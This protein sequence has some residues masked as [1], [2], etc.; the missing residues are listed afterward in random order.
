M[1]R[2]VRTS[3]LATLLGL[4]IL[5]S[6]VPAAA[7]RPPMA[8]GV[9]MYDYKSVAVFD[10][11]VEDSN[12]SVNPKTNPGDLQYPAVWSMWS[13]WGSTTTKKFPTGPIMDKL[14]ANGV[15]PMFFW[16]P[17]VPGQKYD[18]RYRYETIVAGKHDKYIR[19][20]AKAA[21]AYGGRVLLRFAHEM[22]GKWFPWGIGNSTNT[23]SN[24]KAAWR[25]V[26]NIFKSEGATNVKFVWSPNRPCN[27]CVPYKDLYPGNAYVA[28]VG[29]STFNWGAWRD[30][31]WVGLELIS[32]TSMKQFAKVAPTKRVLIAEVASYDKPGNKADWIT[33][34]YQA[35]YDK[36]PKLRAIVY[37]NVNM[38]EVNCGKGQPC[39]PDWR[40]NTPDDDGS[41]DPM[42][43]YADLLLLPRFK[44]MIN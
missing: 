23:A 39:H 18:F 4:L 5:G 33:E 2:P 21:K 22:N 32:R 24:F 20:W 41:D 3:L 1:T 15:A 7:G 6:A 34:G 17:V 16:Q 40:L 28:W 13:D 31:E 37:F 43:A 9:S 30:A 38:T 11:F 42:A 19:N 12:P 14:K 29:Y 27:Q 44:A 25:R 26:Y 10:Q 35:L 8:L 36:Y